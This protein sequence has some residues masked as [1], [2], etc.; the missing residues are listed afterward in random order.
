MMMFLFMIINNCYGLSD[1]F[2]KDIIYLFQ[3]LIPFLFVIGVPLIITLV[4]V[5][6]VETAKKGTELTGNV[7]KSFK[8]K[9]KK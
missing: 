8:K 6:A 4:A 9:R 1:T 3:I 2:N 5:A 7:A